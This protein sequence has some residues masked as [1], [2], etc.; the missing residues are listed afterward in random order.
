MQPFKIVILDVSRDIFCHQLTRWFVGEMFVDRLELG[1]TYGAYI[2]D[3]EDGM[4][5]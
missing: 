1:E 3:I 5:I 4:L 2:E